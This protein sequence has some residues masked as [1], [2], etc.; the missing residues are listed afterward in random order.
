MWIFIIV[1]VL[2]SSLLFF[3]FSFEVDF[4]GAYRLRHSLV[5]NDGMIASSWASRSRTCTLHQVSTSSGCQSK[6]QQQRNFALGVVLTPPQHLTHVALVCSPQCLGHD[7]DEVVNSP[8]LIVDTTYIWRS[9]NRAPPAGQRN[10][11]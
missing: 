7:Q 3:F 5:I 9:R 2:F 6:Q 8:S 10:W 1:L 11:G 4:S